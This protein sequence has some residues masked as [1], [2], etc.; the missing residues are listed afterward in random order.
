MA[1]VIA[2]QL[3]QM[4]PSCYNL[5]ELLSTDTKWELIKANTSLH[6]PA[7]IQILNFYIVILTFNNFSVVCILEIKVVCTLYIGNKSGLYTVYW[8]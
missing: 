3:G 2:V 4:S 6:L 5:E 8:K 1:H 7:V